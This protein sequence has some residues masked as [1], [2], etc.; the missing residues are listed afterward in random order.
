MKNLLTI[1]ALLFLSTSIFSQSNNASKNDGR[2]TLGANDKRLMYGFPV[3]M[4]TSHFIIKIDTISLTNSPY[5]PKGQSIYYIQGKSTS[6]GFMSPKVETEYIFRDYKIVQTLTPMAKNLKDMLG[7]DIAAQYYRWT[8][9]VTNKGKKACNVGVIQLYDNMIDNNDAC[10]MRIGEEVVDKERLILKAQIP[11]SIYVYQNTD[12][13][14]SLIAEL[15]PFLNRADAPDELVIGNW[16]YLHGVLWDMIISPDKPYF[17]SAIL[18]KWK[19]KALKEGESIMHE[20]IYGLPATKPAALKIITIEPNL[21][22]KTATIYFGLNESRLDY[23]GE[24]IVRDLI[25]NTT[26]I[27]GVVLHGFS[28]AYG[29]SK[30][31]IELAQARIDIVSKVFASLKIPVVPK[32]HGNFNADFSEEAMKKGNAF[33][34]K[35][36]IE[37]Y[38]AE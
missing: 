18:L 3:P 10:R 37:L 28:D 30:G 38:Y 22:S 34:R 12:D 21:K 20:S 25:A 4:S 2:F 36:V 24:M 13:P 26:K 7:G 32:S 5:F 23:N 29:G 17:D 31:A 9:T 15:K 1:L 16:P 33:D 35:V 11:A 14:K 19:E 27:K 6:V 8:L